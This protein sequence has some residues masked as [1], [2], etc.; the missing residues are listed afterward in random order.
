MFGLNVLKKKARYAAIVDIGSGSVGVAIVKSVESTESPEIIWSFRERVAVRDKVT[1]DESIKQITTAILNTFLEIGSSGAKKLREFDNEAV[2]ETVRVSISAPWS[3]TITKTITLNQEKPFSVTPNLV[4]ELSKKAGEQAKEIMDSEATAKKLSLELIANETVN[5]SANGYTIKNFFSRNISKVTLSQL[6]GAAD[7][8]MI[9]AIRD[10]QERVLPDAELQ[11][12]TF[13][14][15]YYKA[16]QDLRPNTTEICLVDVTAAATELGIIRDNVLVHT[17][18]IPYGMYTIAGE[19]SELCD[20]PKEEA[21]GYFKDNGV[22]LSTALENS[23]AKKLFEISTKYETSLAE[24]FHRTG[25]ALSIPK[26]IFLH[27]DIATEVFFQAAI[28]NSA[29]ESTGTDH[30][31][32]PITSQLLTK[33]INSDS[34]IL[35]ST[36]VFHKKLYNSEYLQE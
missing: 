4:S 31:V 8:R 26:T 24:L 27:T 10:A 9:K 16:L 6:T 17:T 18:H 29:K 22:S 11:M 28:K 15:A 19:V 3:Y 35:L 20:L 25:D 2:I 33:E 34:A 36:Y 14:F 7:L 1:F 23:K 30:M 13:M 21:L 12:N 5:V 32:H